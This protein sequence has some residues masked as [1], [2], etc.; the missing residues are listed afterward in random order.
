MSNN[1]VASKDQ[2]DEAISV[3]E[4]LNGD[5]VKLEFNLNNGL[6]HIKT[7]CVELRKKVTLMRSHQ[8]NH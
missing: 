7:K 5:L 6:E 4:K 2:K 8:L 1:Q 3:I